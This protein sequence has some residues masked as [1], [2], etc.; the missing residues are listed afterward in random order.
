MSGS[1]NTTLLG[2]MRPAENASLNSEAALLLT[3]TEKEIEFIVKY[4]PDTTSEKYLVL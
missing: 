1:D 3:L 4:I 2:V